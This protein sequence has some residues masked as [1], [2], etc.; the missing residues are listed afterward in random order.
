[1]PSFSWPRFLRQHRIN[2]VTSGPNTARDTISIRCPWCGD[3]DPSQHLGISLK[4]RGW[5]CLR[6]AGHRG[7]SPVWLVQKLL[8]VGEAEARRLVGGDAVLA[9]T[10]SDLATSFAALQTHAGFVAPQKPVPLAMPK[11]FKPLLNGS[12]FAQP[13]L[14]YLEDRGYRTAQIKWLA[15]NYDLRY[16]TTGLY[17][18]RV[19]LPIYNRYGTLLSWTARTIRDD[20]TP[21]YRTLRVR[22]DE[23]YPDNPVAL[24]AANDTLLGLPV[25][26]G[27]DNPRVLI[28]VEGPFDALKL[29]AFGCK[30]GLYGAAV[31]GLNFYAAQLAEIQELAGRFD[32]VYMLVDEDAELQRLRLRNAL[33]SVNCR[34]L[35]MPPGTDDPGA[36]SGEQVVNLALELQATAN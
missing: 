15:E 31:F 22:P 8:G 4:G 17:A 7:K 9:P 25:L 16:A 33:A 11:E 19:I 27:A 36:M 2:Y 18:Y 20:V 12:L 23:R 26:W 32:R 29:T 30:L 5:G 6:N 35:K 10:Q 34:P 14:A 3:G 1:M 21:R 28:L 13:F 24:L